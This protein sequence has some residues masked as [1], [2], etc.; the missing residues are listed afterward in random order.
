M[1]G[2][3]YQ[4]ARRNAARERGDCLTCCRVQAV[5]GTTRCHACA[6]RHR[7]QQNAYTAKLRAST[8]K[9][10]RIDQ[11]PWCTECLAAGFHRE[12]CPEQRLRRAA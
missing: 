12:G 8:G 4:R 7:G 9:S 5:T 6:V 2:A 1:T 11:P 3:D 10:A